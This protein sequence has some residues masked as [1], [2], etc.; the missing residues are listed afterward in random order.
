MCVFACSSVREK[1]LAFIVFTAPFVLLV[2]SK[3]RADKPSQVKTKSGA[4][5][6]TR[7]GEGVIE[8]CGWGGFL[9]L[10]PHNMLPARIDVHDAQF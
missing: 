9:P 8:K 7:S 4:G 1:Y 5:C 6:I 2:G 3:K 10:G